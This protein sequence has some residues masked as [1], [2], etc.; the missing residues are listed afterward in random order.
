M[1]LLS[2]AALVGLEEA[3]CACGCSG[4]GCRAEMLLLLSRLSRNLQ[5]ML[6]REPELLS[7]IHRM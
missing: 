5:C 6:V 1:A 3:S 7:I 4:D 2:P